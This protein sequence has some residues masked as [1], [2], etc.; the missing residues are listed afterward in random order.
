MKTKIPL[1]IIVLAI[2]MCG[3]SASKIENTQENKDILAAEY[4]P[5]QFQR[6]ALVYLRY[7]SLDE[8]ISNAKGDVSFII[9]DK[10]TPMKPVTFSYINTPED[11]GVTAI[12]E[13]LDSQGVS[14]NNEIVLYPYE[15]TVKDVFGQKDI[16][17]KTVLLVGQYFSHVP[18][19]EGT[20][21]ILVSTDT[22]VPALWAEEYE[23]V[24]GKAD[25]YVYLLHPEL[26]YFYIS[27]DK[28]II[29]M[30][31]ANS[32]DYSSLIGLTFDEFEK[33]MK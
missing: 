16:D 7:P 12:E 27:G 20:M 23:K 33:L 25:T 9:A 28:T 13:K 17:G 24:Y 18:E 2:L 14:P 4:P 6:T 19:I 11:K 15:V 29:P 10:L 5:Y 8:L 30:C 32:E 31:D 22:N 3:Y 21:G 1:I 26:S